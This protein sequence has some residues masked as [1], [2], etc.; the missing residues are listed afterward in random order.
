[1]KHEPENSNSSREPDTEPIGGRL[2]EPDAA[3]M[4]EF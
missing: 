4:V 1:M 2:V 3:P